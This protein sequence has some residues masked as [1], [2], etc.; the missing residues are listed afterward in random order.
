NR[1][2][3]WSP[4]LDYVFGFNQDIRERAVAN[5]WLSTDTLNN[6]QFINNFSE[7][8]NYRVNY[9]PF[10]NFRFEITGTKRTAE[11]YSE[12]FKAD[13]FGEYQSYAAA[14]SGSYSVSVITWG[15]AF[16]NDEL[17]DNRSVNFEHMK[18]TRLD[19]ATR[20]AEQNPNWVSAGRPMQLDTLSGQ[21]YPLG[22]GPTQQ[23]VLVPAFLAAYTGQ[24]ATNVGLTS[25]PLIPMPNWRL[26]WNGLTQ[27]P[28][29]KQYFRNIN[30]T[31]SY[32]SSYNIGSYQTNLL[33]EELFGYPVAIDD[34]GNYISQNLMNVV[35]ISE[36]FSPL[37][38]FDIT[39]VNS[40]LARFEI[41]K[42]RNLTM[43]FVNNQL[44]EVKSNEYIIGLGYRFQDVQ[45]TVRTV[46]G[47]GK[48]SRVKSD[49]NV[50]FD[51]SMRDNKTMLRRL[52][53]EV[54]QASSGQRIFSINTSADYQM[55]RNLT[56][57]LFYDQTLTKPHIASQYPNS[58]INS[59]ISVRFTL[60][61]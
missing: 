12:I 27:I 20:L 48:K 57:R 21:M 25:F 41:K 28:W 2:T 55:N 9:E 11:N 15:T 33:Y 40:L 24:D 60:A 3:D 18:A 32:K 4:G 52:D 49:L 17:E 56:L 23:D 53:E 31:H 43:S 50:K 38:N 39:M 36:Q 26:T 14:R 29:I 16:G 1:T 46:G 37:I 51:F 61:Q 6:S 7:N 54:N 44:T 22:Y 59:G 30:I 19:I 42:S 45:F 10:K 47:S 5:S 58:T 34:A 35:T 13:A 8:I